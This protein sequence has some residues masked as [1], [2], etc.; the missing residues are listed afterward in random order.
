[1]KMKPCSREHLPAVVPARTTERIRF[2]NICTASPAGATECRPGRCE[3]S[4]RS[5]TARGRP[6]AWGRQQRARE[7]FWFRGGGRGISF[8]LET[9]LPGSPGL[10]TLIPESEFPGYYCFRLTEGTSALRYGPAGAEPSLCAMAEMTTKGGCHT[11]P[12]CRDAP[13][14]RLR[15]R[16]NLAL[17]YHIPRSPLRENGGCVLAR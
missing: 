17:P 2:S 8:S 12:G 9:H 11:S 10:N 13:V 3:A 4:P 14:A 7:R 16:W 5:C 6:P 1:M 15:P